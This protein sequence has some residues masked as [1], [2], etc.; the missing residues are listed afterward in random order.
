MTVILFI[1][2]SCWGSFLMAAADRYRTDQSLLFPASHCATCQTPLPPWQLVPVL[3][4]LCLRGRCLTCHTPIPPVT[5]AMEVGVGL[6]ATHVHD[7]PSG[8]TYLELTLWLLAALCDHTTQ[9]FPGWISLVS[10]LLTSWDHSVLLV[11][12]ISSLLLVVRWCWPRWPRPLIGDG[13]LEVML[14]YGLGHS[15]TASATWLLTACTGALLLTRHSA[16]PGRIAFI[17]YLTASAVW[18]W[19]WP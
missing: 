19:L 11:L 12:L 2:G 3:S 18:W 5:L 13:D 14:C 6:L 1:Y 9:T 17:P 8:L 15:L 4:Y 16:L 7:W 10:L